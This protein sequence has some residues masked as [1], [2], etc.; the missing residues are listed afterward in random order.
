MAGGRARR[1]P[2][3]LEYAIDGR[4]ILAR[5]Y[6]AVRAAGWPVYVAGAS[7]VL[8]RSRRAPGRAAS[9]RS[10]A[11]RRS[12]ERLSLGKCCRFAR[13]AS[14]PSPEISRASTCACCNG[15]MARGSP[16]TKRSCRSTTGRSS[17]L[18]RSIRVAQ[19]FAKA[20]SCA[21]RARVRC[22][23][24]SSVSAL[25]LWRSTRRYFHNVNRIEDVPMR[26]ER[27]IA[28]FA[29]ARRIIAGG[30]NSPVRALGA[31]GLSPIFMKSAS[32]AMLYDLDGHEYIDYVMSWGALLLGHAHPAVTRAIVNVAAPWNLVW[33]ADRTGE[34]AC[35]AYRLDD[36]VDRALAVRLER[37]RSDDDRD[38]ACARF[39]RIVRRSSSS[40]AAITDTAIRF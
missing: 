28:A 37:Y 15:L 8:V 40:P 16:A 27:S 1:F 20:S 29:R 25:D 19:S 7:F 9:D 10:P 18:P 22:A 35:R 32:G 34:R 4:P 38:S 23:T 11:G 6:D 2:G 30:V 3:K 12:F 33:N 31:V 26:L 24:S 17:R 39:H 13:S 14:S 5:C 21:E 36:A